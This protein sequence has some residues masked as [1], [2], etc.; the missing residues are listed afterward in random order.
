M[1]EHVRVNTASNTGLAD[2]IEVQVGS[3]LLVVSVMSRAIGLNEGENKNETWKVQPS[4]VFAKHIVRKL[5]CCADYELFRGK[6][7][8]RLG[9]SQAGR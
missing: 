9:L 7:L 4:N 1:T 6:A 2:M 5:E 3:C 8:R